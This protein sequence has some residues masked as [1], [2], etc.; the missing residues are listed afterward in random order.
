MISR[1]MP[2][3]VLPDG[4]LFKRGRVD[5]AALDPFDMGGVLTTRL[6]SNWQHVPVAYLRPHWLAAEVAGLD[7]PKPIELDFPYPPC[8]RC[9]VET[10]HDGDGFTCPQC[11]ARWSD[12]GGA[13][14]MPC[15]EDRDHEAS[16]V[17][18]DGQ[19]RCVLCET[20]VR[21][22]EIEDPAEPYECRRCKTKVIGIGVGFDT[23]A[24]TNRRCGECQVSVEG[25]EWWANW[26]ASR[27]EKS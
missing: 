7:K 26:R 18:A 27:G 13:G 6:E 25:A 15:V 17:G 24:A 5:V 10:E 14:V 16:V 19:P 22:G 4:D 11:L 9:H 2:V 8:S 23:G 3:V 1:G 12:R 21:S 20:R